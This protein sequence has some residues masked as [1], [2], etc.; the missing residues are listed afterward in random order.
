SFA[1]ISDHSLEALRR[2][3]RL[4]HV[5]G[6]HVKLTSSGH[7]SM[8]GCCPFH[9]DKTPSLSVD[10]AKG[11]YH[12]FGCGAGGDV[13]KFVMETERLSFA[14]AAKTLAEQ[15]GVQLTYEGG[16]G[17][18]SAD[19]SE[20]AQAA[21]DAKL[22][23]RDRLLRALQL[24]AEFYARSLSTARTAGAARA[25]L[26]SRGVSPATALRFQLGYSPAEAPG[27]VLQHLMAQGVEPQTLVQAGLAY[28]NT[29]SG[30]GGGGAPLLD[31]FRGRL[32]VPIRD[33]RGAVVAFGGREL[34]PPAAA[35]ADAAATDAVDDAPPPPPPVRKVP[36]Y[37]NSPE[38]DV[39]H[40]GGMLFGL[41]A[42]RDAIRDEDMAVLVEGYFDVIALH[43]AGVR[44]AVGALGTAVTP[45]QLDLAARH[46][47][48]RRVV[49]C[50]DADAAG[51]KAVERLCEGGALEEAAANGIEVRVADIAAAAP[52]C[53][54]PSDFVA[55]AAAAAATAAGKGGKAPWTVW[56]TDRVL[57]AHDHGGDAA[58]FRACVDKL[59]T[60][61]SALADPADR[62]NHVYR[63]AAALSGDNLALRLQ[64]EADLM[65]MVAAKEK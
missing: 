63:V 20:A 18:Y 54:D 64:L 53:K 37:L 6:E 13:I 25:H 8:K 33:A 31:R 11:L 44:C 35:R 42:A 48:G 1:R 50:M 58:A 55:E 22:A 17:G 21:R 39:F 61:L 34:P 24:A 56:Y 2:T 5:I 7:T 10:D 29:A 4:S 9:D 30:G 28:N 60:F 36:K 15:H 52:G 12:C 62:T 3:A 27:A 41:D 23:Q 51:A 59:T 43:G 49:L 16:G 57:A 14:A 19:M 65:A 38:T 45:R 40:K 32:I 26:A 46:S 47:R